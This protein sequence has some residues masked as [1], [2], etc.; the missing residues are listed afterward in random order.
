MARAQWLYDRKADLLPVAYFLVV[1]SV[2]QEVAAIA[3]Q[4][5]EVVFNILFQATAQTLRTIGAD[6]QHLDAEIG[7]IAILHTWGQNLLHHPHLHCV[8]LRAPVPVAVVDAPDNIA[9]N[10]FTGGFL[11]R[12]FSLWSVEKTQKR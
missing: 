8:V 9:P 11:Q 1:F 4:N 10:Q 12:I 7:F 5:K 3:H 2:P 6:S